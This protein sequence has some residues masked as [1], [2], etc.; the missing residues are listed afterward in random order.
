MNYYK[1]IT[2]LFDKWAKDLQKMP[3][4]E[5]KELTKI[6]MEKAVNLFLGKVYIE[7]QKSKD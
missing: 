3:E 7:N 6:E 1:Q 5:E 2:D 4:G